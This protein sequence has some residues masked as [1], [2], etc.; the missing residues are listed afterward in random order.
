M[1]NAT[2]YATSNNIN[3]NNEITS[4]KSASA[5]FR[6]VCDYSSVKAFIPCDINGEKETVSRTFFN[7][8]ATNTNYGVIDRLITYP[9]DRGWG[10]AAAIYNS[11]NF[12]YFT[13]YPNLSSLT[14]SKLSDFAG[15]PD[16]MWLAS[17]VHCSSKNENK[18]GLE[19][20]LKTA[21]I[22][23]HYYNVVKTAK[24]TE[25]YGVTPI[26]QLK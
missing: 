23:T 25:Y 11:A 8:N 2:I 10:G 9:H 19:E 24:S 16:A 4:T 26:I 20:T 12:C 14:M 18:D 1:F 13:N 5:G 21:M 7:Y 15:D 6:T 22:K 3:G 17:D